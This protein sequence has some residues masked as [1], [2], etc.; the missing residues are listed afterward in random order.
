MLRPVT[1]RSRR[2]RDASL[3]I[4]VVCASFHSCGRHT[5][6]ARHLVLR[7]VYVYMHVL[8][9]CA[10]YFAFVVF[11]S[12]SAQEL[13]CHRLHPDRLR[14][15]SPFSW[16]LGGATASAKRFTKRRAAKEYQRAQHP[17]ED[18][19]CARTSTLYFFIDACFAI[20]IALRIRLWLIWD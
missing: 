5:L 19:Q 14:E 1:Q 20:G 13:H 17:P 6:P 10:F 3:K 2:T 4:H 7:N 8:Y 12:F 9:T 18:E 16:R 11:P 15:S